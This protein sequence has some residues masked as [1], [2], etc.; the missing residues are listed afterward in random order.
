MVIGSDKP[1]DKNLALSTFTT[2]SSG[3]TVVLSLVLQEYI[4]TLKAQRL[5]PKIDNVSLLIF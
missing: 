2:T 4:V 1:A 5:N 3:V